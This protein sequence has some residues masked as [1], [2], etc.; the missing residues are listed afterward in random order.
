MN[1]INNFTNN[2][3]HREN[4]D[5]F[6]QVQSLQ[7]MSVTDVDSYSPRDITQVQ[8]DSVIVNYD[9][10]TLNPQKCIRQINELS[11]RIGL[12][13]NYGKE[14]ILIQNTM[15]SNMQIHFIV[16]DQESQKYKKW[17]LSVSEDKPIVEDMKFFRKNENDLWEYLKGV[18]NDWIPYNGGEFSDEE[19]N[20]A[21]RKN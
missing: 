18:E 7:L 4:Y 6:V 21:R 8:N 10:D 12:L 19:I 2:I 14:F 3:P 20:F 9:H 17:Y 1:N 15:Y 13:K 16:K 11:W 5:N